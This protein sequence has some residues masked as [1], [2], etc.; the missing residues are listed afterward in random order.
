MPIAANG[1][2]TGPTGAI[3]SAP[4]NVVRSATWNTINID[5]ATALTQ[6]AQQVFLPT[7]RTVVSGSFTV[8]VADTAV[9][10]KGNSPTIVLPLSSTKTGIVRIFGAATTVFGS[11][12]ALVIATSPDTISGTGTITLTTNYQVAAFYPLST[13]GYIKY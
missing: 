6:L 7:P 11:V 8:A 9:L 10:V 5:V 2:Y 13:G 12:N 3:N 4:G 1:V